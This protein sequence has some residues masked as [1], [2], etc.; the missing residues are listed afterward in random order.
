MGAPLAAQTT[1]DRGAVRFM[2]GAAK[3][4]IDEPWQS[5]WGASVR[6]RVYKR[7]SLEPE[8]AFSPGSPYQQWTFVPNL[9]LDLGQ[10]G[11]R[12]T[13][14]V[15]GGVGYVHKVEFRYESGGTAWNGGIG[16]RIR[17]GRRAFV[18]PEF[19]FGIITRVVVSAGYSF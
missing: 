4:Y 18:A 3:L 14:Y 12:V 19:R 10:P 2:A 6:L 8:F 9:V 15:I 5:V 11:R 17:A 1:A 13:P 7:L 16:V